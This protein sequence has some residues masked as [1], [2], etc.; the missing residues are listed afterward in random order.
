[1]EGH[2][3]EIRAIVCDM[4]NHTLVSQLKIR[5]HQYYFDNPCDPTRKVYVFPDAPHLLKCAR[6]ALLDHGFSIPGSFR[7]EEMFPLKM[8]HFEELIRK[9]DSELT[10]LFKL[11]PRDHLY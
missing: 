9:N 8:E 4:G 10:P 2:G 1:M 3:F 6:G 5:D 11:N 7:S